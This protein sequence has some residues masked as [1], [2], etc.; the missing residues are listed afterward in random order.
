LDVV[1]HDDWVSKNSI[2]RQ[3]IY[4]LRRLGA[5]VTLGASS[6]ARISFAEPA[7]ADDSERRP[8]GKGAQ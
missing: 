2:C 1:S 5:N 8:C 4:K 6:G 7:S 3:D